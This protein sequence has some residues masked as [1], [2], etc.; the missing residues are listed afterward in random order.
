MIPDAPGFFLF[1]LSDE[2]GRMLHVRHQAG[3][4]ASVERVTR[5]MLSNWPFFLMVGASGPGIFERNA[6]PRWMH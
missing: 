2:I 6:S 3:L 1:A 4:F 5:L